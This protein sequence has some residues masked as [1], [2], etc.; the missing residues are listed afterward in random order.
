MT[1]DPSA[2]ARAGWFQVSLKTLFSL[3]LVVAAF[4]AGEA[5]SQRRTE[6]AVRD[7][8]EAADVARQQ[9]DQSRLELALER[10]KHGLPPPPL[11]NE[12]LP[13]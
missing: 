7:A 4:F 3:V 10:G 11:P 13:P 9:E 2:S 5:I 6:K 8:Q 1:M 12:D